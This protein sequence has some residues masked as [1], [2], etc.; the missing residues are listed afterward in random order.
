[1]ILTFVKTLLDIATEHGT[2]K[3]SHGFCPFYEGWLSGKRGVALRLLEVGVSKGASMRTWREYLPLAE[4]HGADIN[5]ADPIDG[6]TLHRLNASRLDQLERFAA[7]NGD[8][9]VVIDDGG[10]SME[11]QQLTFLTLWPRVSPG[12]L[13][14]VEDLHS[15]FDSGCLGCCV[16]SNST[17]E[18]VKALGSGVFESPFVTKQQFAAAA[19]SVADVALWSR[20][21][22][23]DPL[24]MTRND[25]ITSVIVKRP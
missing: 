3:A 16:A 15:S 2:D 8:W 23:G 13:Y 6:V 4:V 5:A 17:L 22:V 9:G 12:G 10:H 11:Q 19:A 25:S 18:M 7:A 14:I 1:M 21:P 24:R 20:R